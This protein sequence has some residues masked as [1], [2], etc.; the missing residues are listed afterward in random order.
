MVWKAAY[1]PRFRCHWLAGGGAISPKVEIQMSKEAQRSNDQKGSQ[2]MPL[3]RSSLVQ[4]VPVKDRRFP[5]DAARQGFASWLSRHRLKFGRKLLGRMDDREDFGA[6]GGNTI[7]D[8]IGPFKHFYIGDRPVT[9]IGQVPYDAQ[10]S[11]NGAQSR[12]SLKHLNIQ[13]ERPHVSETVP[14]RGVSIWQNR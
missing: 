13:L 14:W 6:I 10:L 9:T 11:N 3:P 8:P 5:W 4:E 2:E 12:N 7:D 1:F